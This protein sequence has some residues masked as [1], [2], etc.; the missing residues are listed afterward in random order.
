MSHHL[1]AELPRAYK[2]LKDKIGALFK[3]KELISI[4]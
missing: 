4:S 1:I 3:R 2:R